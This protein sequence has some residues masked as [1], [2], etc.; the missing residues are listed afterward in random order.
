MSQRTQDPDHGA[1][2]HYL[3]DPQLPWSAVGLL[4]YFEHNDI[5]T[6][7]SAELLGLNRAAYHWH[8]NDQGD[9]RF[10]WDSAVAAGY[11]QEVDG[12]WVI[13]WEVEE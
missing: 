7:G 5:R 4:A 6:L 8:P 1:T 9:L 2:I 10:A 3:D 11:A 12:Q 13:R